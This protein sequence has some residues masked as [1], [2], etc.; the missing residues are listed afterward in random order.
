MEKIK[1]T[2]ICGKNFEVYP[3]LDRIK[4]CS[5]E[6]RHKFRDKGWVKKSN[7]IQVCR[8]G[9]EFRVYPYMKDIQKFCSKPCANKFRIQNQGGYKNPKGS[10]AKIGEKNP[11]F[12]K[13]KDNPSYSAIHHYIH[14]RLDPIKPLHCEHCRLKKDLDLANK[15]RQYKRDLNDWLWLCRKC[16]QEY[17]GH[18]NNLKM[19]WK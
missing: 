15:S 7:I 12:G 2:C 17:D 5:N 8:C 19:R 18:G 4:F 16:H 11:Q 1:K 13:I 6:C 9:K 10:V 3:S 14:K